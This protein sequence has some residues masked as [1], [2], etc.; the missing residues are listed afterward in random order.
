MGEGEDAKEV[1]S[2]VVLEKEQCEAGD[3]RGGSGLPY[4]V[5]SWDGE[6]HI[7]LFENDF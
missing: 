5:L 2:L 1:W 6:S 3:Y 4:R 7:G